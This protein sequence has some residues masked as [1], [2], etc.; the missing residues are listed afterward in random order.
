MTGFAKGEIF[1]Q[2]QYIFSPS[3]VVAASIDSKRMVVY[4]A[5]KY[6]GKSAQFAGSIYGIAARIYERYSI[7]TTALMVKYLAR[8]L[9]LRMWNITA[10]V[11]FVF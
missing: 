10:T 7:D 5:V 8:L 1:A 11:R 3:T 6:E 2:L 9:A 4:A